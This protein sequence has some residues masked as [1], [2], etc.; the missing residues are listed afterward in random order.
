MRSGCGIKLKTAI[1]WN[2]LPSFW[3][4]TGGG[5]LRMTLILGWVTRKVQKRLSNSWTGVK[6]LM[7]NLSH[8][9]YF[10]P[11]TFVVHQKKS[12]RSCVSLRRSFRKLL[13]DE[14]IHRNKVHV[15]VI[16]RVN[17]LPESLQTPNSGR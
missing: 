16:G 4:E 7:S 9:T 13:T 17:L 15:K 12:S 2:I 14:R 6:N 3:M 1:V 5:L 10:Q 8:F 11:R